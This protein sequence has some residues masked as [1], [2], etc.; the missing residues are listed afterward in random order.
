MFKEITKPML[1][2]VA[3]YAVLIGSYWLYKA[4]T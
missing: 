3:I 4:L 1:Q 2:A